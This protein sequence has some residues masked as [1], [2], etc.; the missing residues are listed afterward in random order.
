MN[1]KSSRATSPP[2]SVAEEIDG[3]PEHL[4]AES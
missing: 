1:G 4:K 3:L 2:D